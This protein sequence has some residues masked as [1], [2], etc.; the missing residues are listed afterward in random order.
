LI[1]IPRSTIRL[2]RSVLRR[3][4]R[5]NAYAYQTISIH[6]G[7]DGL[8]LRRHFG[9]IAIE[10]RLAGSFAKDEF[11]FASEALADFEGRDDEAVTLERMKGGAI[12]AQW[13]D[14]VVPQTKEYEASPL[15]KLPAWPATPEQLVPADGAFWQ[16]LSDAVIS[17]A[18]DSQTRYVLTS[19]QFRGSTGAL[20]ATDGH[21][22]LFQSGLAFPWKED[23]LVPATPLLGSKEF[24]DE[25]PIS[26][27][28]TNTCVTFQAGPWTL[29]LHIEKEGMYP[30]AEDAIPTLKGKFTHWRI[31]PA[32]ADFLATALPRLPGAKEADAPVTVDLNGHVLIR[33]KASD[34]AGTTELVLAHS[35][36]DKP[37]R[38]V[39]NRQLLLRA[40]SLGFSEFDIVDPKTAVQCSDQHRKFAFMP[41]QG[42]PTPATDKATR[43]S[44]DPNHETVSTSPIPL[45]RSEAAM[46]AS[47]ASNGT[48]TNGTTQRDE[49]PESN[50]HSQAGYGALIAEAEAIKTD[51]R[52]IFVRINQLVIA[53]KRHRKT[54]QGV[55][56]MLTNLRQLERIGG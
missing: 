37:V 14:G 56:N 49:T 13:H 36:A 45:E 33:A 22:L 26:F 52:N 2:F 47:T 39:V 9:D 43:I 25:G 29:H 10:Y 48:S 41:I 7:D 51:V 18:K 38:F 53:I 32:D 27:G 21:E 23:C 6:A 34:Q 8:R 16:A 4:G 3:C 11:A 42:T 40:L 31:D 12:R 15:E 20:V 55:Q 44:S 30:K 50:G 17:A 28:R 19:L 24:L 5:K 54:A 46:K 1:Q 35:S